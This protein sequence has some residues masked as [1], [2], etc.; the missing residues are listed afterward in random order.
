MHASYLSRYVTVLV[1][2]IVL[3]MLPTTN[4]VVCRQS[5]YNIHSSQTIGN[6]T[7]YPSAFVCVIDMLS[8]RVYTTLLTC[9]ISYLHHK[10][11]LSNV[12]CRQIQSILRI[13]RRCSH[14]G[15]LLSVCR[16]VFLSALV[17]ACSFVCLR[18]CLCVAIERVRGG[19]ILVKAYAYYEVYLKSTYPSKSS[20]V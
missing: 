9:D 6:Q 12:R 1:C 15:V 2:A 4:S 8:D 13:C 7:F 11:Y 5:N 3:V 17:T 14:L 10:I 16:S 18:V 20:Q 19:L